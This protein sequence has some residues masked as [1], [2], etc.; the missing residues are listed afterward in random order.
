MPDANTVIGTLKIMPSSKNS[1]HSAASRSR[2]AS[3]QWPATPVA[4]FVLSGDRLKFAWVNEPTQ[5]ESPNVEDE[6]IVPGEFFARQ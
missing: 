6:Y 2:A 4:A 5:R 1:W 3:A